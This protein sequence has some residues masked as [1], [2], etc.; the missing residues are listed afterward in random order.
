MIRV[1]CAGTSLTIQGHAGAAPYGQ[2]LVCAAVS[3]L[4]YALAQRLTEQEGAFERPPVIRLEPGS[5]EITA[6]P[7]ADYAVRVQEDFRLIQS[8]L[9]LME[10][11]YPEQLKIS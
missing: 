8:G 10:T 3:A 2:N 5:A 1:T 6:F 9:C 4:V 7:S 11:H